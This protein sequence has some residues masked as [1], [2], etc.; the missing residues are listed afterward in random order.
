LDAELSQILLVEGLLLLLVV[1]E[2]GLVVAGIEA[3]DWWR[4]RRAGEVDRL[5]GG[6]RS[7]LQRN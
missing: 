6:I 2:V 7:A 5:H 4:D 1:L 3:F